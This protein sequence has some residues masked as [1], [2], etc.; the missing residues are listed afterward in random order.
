VEE[1]FE[2]SVR[3]CGRNG[4]RR[5]TGPRGV[6]Y[7]APGATLTCCDNDAD[8]TSEFGRGVYSGSG[9]KLYL[10]FHGRNLSDSVGTVT[11]KND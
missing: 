5:K 2:R 10:I 11:G 8:A 6:M 3:G 1:Y 7:A 4:W 9:K